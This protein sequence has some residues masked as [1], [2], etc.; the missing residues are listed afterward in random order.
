MMLPPLHLCIDG[1]GNGNGDGDGDG[2]GDGNG[3]INAAAVV[4]RVV[5]AAEKTTIN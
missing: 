1:N 3:N 4:D 2:D 5:T